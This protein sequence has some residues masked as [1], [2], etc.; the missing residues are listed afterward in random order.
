MPCGHFPHMRSW[1]TAIGRRS[2]PES[3]RPAQSLHHRRHRTWSCPHQQSWKLRTRQ[4]V[5]AHAQATR[6]GECLPR[7][8][9]PS[10]LDLGSAPP[11][12]RRRWPQSHPCNPLSRSSVARVKCAPWQKVQVLCLAH[13]IGSRSSAPEPCMGAWHLMGQTSKTALGWLQKRPLL[14]VA[15]RSPCTSQTDAWMTRWRAG[16]RNPHPRLVCQASA[17]IPSHPLSSSG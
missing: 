13:R 6:P 7:Q 15:E 1:K 10:A 3:P 2:L 16:S 12:Q 14:P 17:P 5:A 4:M 8:P 11:L 9:P